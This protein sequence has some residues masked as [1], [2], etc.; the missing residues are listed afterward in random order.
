MI[1]KMSN[2]IKFLSEFIDKPN[3]KFFGFTIIY[4]NGELMNH[5]ITGNPVELS[6]RIEE[7]RKLYK[8]IKNGYQEDSHWFRH[9]HIS[10]K[11]GEQKL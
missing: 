10:S 5:F 8:K 3:E 4:K 1:D 6:D 7:L 2:N 9:H 11:K